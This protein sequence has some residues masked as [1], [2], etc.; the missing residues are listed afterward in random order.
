VEDRADAVAVPAFDDEEVLLGAGGG[1]FGAGAE[2]QGVAVLGE[3]GEVSGAAFGEAGEAFFLD[4]GDERVGLEVVEQGLGEGRVL[5]E[6]GRFS[7][8]RGLPFGIVFTACAQTGQGR[9][10]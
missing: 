1:D 5:V 9:R 7:T 3:R 2:A 8:R 4:P 6:G 10:A